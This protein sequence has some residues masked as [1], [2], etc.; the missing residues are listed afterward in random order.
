MYSNIK[1]VQ[2]LLA[3]LKSYNIDKVVVS[4]GNSHNAIVRSLEEDAF[5]KTYSI[6][7]ERSAAF[8]ACGISQELNQP[9]AICCTAGTAASNYLSGVTEAFRRKLP[10]IVITGD[11]HP[12]FLD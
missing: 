10:I 7:D 9:V 6:V 12:Y 3:A 2:Y 5:F 11:K 4:P 1:S 8:F